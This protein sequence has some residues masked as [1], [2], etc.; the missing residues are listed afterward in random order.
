VSHRTSMGSLA[1]RSCELLSC[2]LVMGGLL[3]VGGRR[4]SRELRSSGLR[5]CRSWRWASPLHLHLHLHLHLL[6]L[7]LLLLLL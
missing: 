1:F 6:L 3:G 5:S 4:L 7:P 2:R